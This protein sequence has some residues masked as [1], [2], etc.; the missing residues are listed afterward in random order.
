MVRA[1][2]HPPTPRSAPPPPGRSPVR[3]PAFARLTV[4]LGA[5]KAPGHD[6]TAAFHVESGRVVTAAVARDHRTGH[7]APIARHSV[8]PGHCDPR[9]AGAACTST[10]PAPGLALGSWSDPPREDPMPEFDVD[11]LRA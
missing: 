3:R 10:P 9:R 7:W 11:A 8:R 4:T 1:T 2:T 5:P 6:Q